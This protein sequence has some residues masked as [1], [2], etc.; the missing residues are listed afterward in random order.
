MTAEDLTQQE[1][2]ELQRLRLAISSSVTSVAVE[3]MERFSYLFSKTLVGK[4]DQVGYSVEV[5]PR[6]R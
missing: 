5:R 3:E 6:T 2:D 4:G 1:W